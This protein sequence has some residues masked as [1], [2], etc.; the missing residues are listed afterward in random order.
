MLS[1]AAAWK[2]NAVQ[3]GADACVPCLTVWTCQLFLIHDI[4]A[5]ILKCKFF[6]DVLECFGLHSSMNI[7]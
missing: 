7:S 1:V 6:I 3:C 5:G 2:D 4:D